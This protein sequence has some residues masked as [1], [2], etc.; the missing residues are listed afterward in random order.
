MTVAGG[1]G[2]CAHP[3]ITHNSNHVAYILLEMGVL[4]ECLSK[5]VIAPRVM[6]SLAGA[7]DASAGSAT[8][9]ATPAFRPDES[10]LAR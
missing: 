4:C 8:A 1:P 7:K 6:A 5:L 2:R 10:G 9:E 3:T